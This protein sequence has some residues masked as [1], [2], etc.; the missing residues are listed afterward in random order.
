M[1][2]WQAG[3]QTLSRQ[4]SVTSR[5]GRGRSKTW[6][7]S[8]SVTGRRERSS[9][10]EQRVTGR[11]TTVSG[12]STA[13]RVSPLCPGCP[14]G[15]FPDGVRRLLGAG[16]R[17]PS[18]E[19]GLGAVLGVLLDLPLELFDAGLFFGE[20][21]LLLSKLCNQQGDFLCHPVEERLK[22][23]DL[24]EKGLGVGFPEGH[25]TGDP[26]NLQK[27]GGRL[28]LRVKGSLVVS[29]SFM[30]PDPRSMGAQNLVWPSH[31]GSLDPCL[32]EGDGKD[33][34]GFFMD[35]GGAE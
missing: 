1:T 33:P 16:F 2:F 31:R 19:G 10:Q 21:S 15:F 5:R 32:V 11:F 34:P 29:G 24:R 13:S 7:H 28:L 14:P 23:M 8:C 35:Q 22:P 6:R 30:G 25:E 18:L 27:R 4:Y 20:K 3:Q 26:G 9:P 17:T 12:V